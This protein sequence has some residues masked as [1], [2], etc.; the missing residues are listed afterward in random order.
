LAKQSGV[1]KNWLATS[2][3]RN[4]P[5]ITFPEAFCCVKSRFQIPQ[6]P[7]SDREAKLRMQCAIKK[8]SQKAVI[9]FYFLRLIGRVHT[10]SNCK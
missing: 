5:E 8:K 4:F 10:K 3:A 1:W 6:L 2:L 9:F 7:F